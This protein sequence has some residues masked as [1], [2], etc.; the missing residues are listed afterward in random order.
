M[1]SIAN[2]T[3]NAEP[4]FPAFVLDSCIIGLEKLQS[5][6]ANGMMFGYAQSLI[7]L[8]PSICTLGYDRLVEQTSGTYSFESVASYR[9]LLLKIESWQEPLHRPY[10][11]KT[12]TELIS[13][14]EAYRT[15]I[16]IFLHAAFYATNVTTPE[17]LTLIDELIHAS[18]LSLSFD[19]DSPVLSVMLW[20]CMIIGSCLRDPFQ[21]A[22]IRSKMLKAPFNMTIVLNS[23]QLLDWLWEDTDP[24]IYGP[25]GLGIVMKKHGVVHSMG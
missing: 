4:T 11:G 19:E 22:Y 13:A 21:R 20:P 24:N 8:I 3:A 25:Y 2:I 6:K 9:A 16:L 17:A 12:E 1:V 23:V 18:F 15:A 14:A 5:C 10:S 7:T